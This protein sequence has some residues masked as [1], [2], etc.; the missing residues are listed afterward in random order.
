M[1][2]LRR[3][4]HDDA[5]DAEHVKLKPLLPSPPQW[6]SSSLVSS[7]PLSQP[8]LLLQRLQLN[9][10]LNERITFSLEQYHKNVIKKLAASSLGKFQVFRLTKN[11]CQT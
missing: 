6:P 7:L 8:T 9:Q 5:S 3:N 10:H 4:C 1:L 11:V 2:G